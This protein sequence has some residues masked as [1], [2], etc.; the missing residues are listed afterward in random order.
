MCGIEDPWSSMK[1]VVK[2]ENMDTS[3]GYHPTMPSSGSGNAP[4]GNAPIGY[5]PNMSPN[6]PHGAQMHPGLTHQH[7]M[8]CTHGAPHPH[9]GVEDFNS[10]CHGG[11]VMC[12]DAGS[13]CLSSSG[14]MATPKMENKKDIV[15]CKDTTGMRHPCSQDMAEGN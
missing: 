14:N 9:H 5:A 10:N 15:V 7:S 2:F 13:N 11:N 6:Q 12:S 1:H 3:G 4:N 8:D